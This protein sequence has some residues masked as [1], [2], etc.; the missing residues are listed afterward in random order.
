[1]YLEI[2]QIRGMRH[3]FFVNAEAD[4]TKHNADKRIDIM[5]P[6]TFAVFP[7][8]ATFPQR[9]IKSLLAP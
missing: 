3:I 7:G 5:F 4:K 9:L 1:M 6:I 2:S 8:F